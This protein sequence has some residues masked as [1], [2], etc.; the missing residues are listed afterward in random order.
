MDSFSKTVSQL[1]NRLCTSIAMLARVLY[2]SNH[3][4]EN[5]NVYFSNNLPNVHPIVPQNLSKNVSFSRLDS[6]VSYADMLNEI[7]GQE[8]GTIEENFLVVI[9][10]EL[11]LLLY[12]YTYGKVSIDGNESNRHYF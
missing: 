2:I 5:Q 7:Q 6:F 9:K 10:K 1:G 11:F 8:N 4:T 12:T 3:T